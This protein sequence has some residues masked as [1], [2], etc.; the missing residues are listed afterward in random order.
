M[1]S[2]IRERR[3]PPQAKR[4]LGEYVL[5]TKKRYDPAV[6][7]N[8]IL[9][10]VPTVHRVEFDLLKKRLIVTSEMPA[11]DTDRKALQIA[12]RKHKAGRRR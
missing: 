7:W 11:N 6:L 5:T 2:W 9:R 4:L 1:I 8:E 10:A 3:K 12:M